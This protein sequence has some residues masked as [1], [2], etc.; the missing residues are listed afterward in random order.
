VI[1]T[2]GFHSETLKKLTKW[3]S[4][5]RDIA[6]N[7]TEAE[8]LTVLIRHWETGD[9]QD[10]VRYS[11]LWVADNDPTV[12]FYHGVT[13]PYRDPSGVRC[14]YQSMVAAINPKES[15]FLHQFVAESAKILPLLPHPPCYERKTFV[16]PTYNAVN[17]LTYCCSGMPIGYNLPNYDEIRF[18]KGSKNVSFS[19]VQT[20]GSITPKLFPF[21]PEDRLPNTI[22]LY[23]S[24]VPLWTAG[25]ELYGHGSGTQLKKEDVADG[26]V[27]DLLHPHRSVST[28]WEEDETYAAVFG[29]DGPSIEECRAET[30]SLYLITKDEV[31][32]MYGV[33]VDRRMAF[34]TSAMLLLTQSG[35]NRLVTYQPESS[36]WTSPYG[37]ARVAI[38][39][40]VLIWGRGSMTLKKIDGRYKLQIYDEKFDGVVDALST[41]LKH[42][43]YYRAAKLPDQAREFIGMLTSMDDFWLD[44]RKQSMQDRGPKGV[45]CAAVVRKTETGYTLARSGGTKVTAL[46]V[47]VAAVETS[48]LALE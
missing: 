27:P 39:R 42:L 3:L 23:S 11:E 8:A 29:G 41:L 44:V 35:L 1:V 21:I 40:A 30:T 9:I 22:E 14:E 13:D 2:K 47:A 15:Q 6:L 28:Y 4:L 19:N 33:P 31:L 17:V 45:E 34:K 12:E 16:A 7:P 38:L 20:A 46:D 37:R 32:E 48:A 18:T 25:H 36:R 24:I 26:K 5:A 10:H 43:N